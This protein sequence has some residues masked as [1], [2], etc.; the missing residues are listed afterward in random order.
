MSEKREQ[1]VQPTSAVSRR[2]FLRIGS[3]CGM[4]A[5]LSAAAMLGT[6]YSAQALAQTA[7]RVSAERDKSTAKHVLKL[8]MVY[9]DVQHDIQRVGVWD[10][11]RDLEQRTDGAI[12]VEVVDSGA[13]CSETKCTQQAM[14]GVIDFS[15]SS[16]QN[17][18]SVA[19]WMNALDF[20]FMFQ[21]PG[22]IYDFFFNPESER[23]FRQVLRERH[24]LELLFSTG[25]LRGVLM[26][27]TFADKPPVTELAQL[28]GAR[29][30]ATATQFG[31]TALKLM[32]MSPL[33]VAW[34]ETLDAMRSGLVDG[35][36]TWP[37]AAA[38]F[39]MAPVVT[40][41]VTLGFI[42]GTEAT[43]IRT[44]SFEKLQSDL[45]E[46]VLESA[47]VAQQVVMYNL[48]AAR[49]AIIGDVPNASPDSI[50]SKS[51]TEINEPPAEMLAA[52]REVADPMNEAYAPIRDRLNQMAGFDVYESIRPAAQ[53]I[54]ASVDVINVV[55]RRW[56]KSA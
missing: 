48:A 28:E 14:Q 8:G 23:I 30:R 49:Y 13:L 43:S 41:L 25:E 42:P 33:P 2:D 5:T 20:P 29:I 46:A 55:P 40:K 21:S 47:Y 12:Q 19:P 56:W 24:K 37:G 38:A 22:Q 44:E 3:T 17:A 7:G 32:G 35:M 36:E 34:G 31:Q 16:T 50:Y 39:N 18:A 11:V 51:G 6:G 27:A 15:V 26:G 52:C 9:G 45:Q 4:T 54:D 10:F 1:A 53:R